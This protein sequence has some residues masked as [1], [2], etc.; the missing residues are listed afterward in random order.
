MYD[1]NDIHETFHPEPRDVAV[2]ALPCVLSGGLDTAANAVVGAICKSLK[3]LQEQTH[4]EV[5]DK[6]WADRI[7]PLL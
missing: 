6:I 1:P 3:G 7:V 4:Q 5:D 2:A